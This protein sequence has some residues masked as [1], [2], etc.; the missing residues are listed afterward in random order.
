V[1]SRYEFSQELGGNLGMNVALLV[2][3]ISENYQLSEV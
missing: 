3:L 1:Q 2:F